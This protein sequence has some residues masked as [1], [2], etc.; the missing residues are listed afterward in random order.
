MPIRAYNLAVDPASLLVGGFDETSERPSRPG[1]ERRSAKPSYV[2]QLGTTVISTPC[3]EVLRP[4][5]AA[6]P[7]LSVLTFARPG[8][9]FGQRPLGE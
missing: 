8:S 2:A 5:S 1:D 4:M 9:C 7:G 3:T 6:S